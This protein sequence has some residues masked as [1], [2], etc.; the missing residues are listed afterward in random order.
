MLVVSA[1][2]S[3]AIDTTAFRACV[4]DSELPIPTGTAGVASAA[5]PNFSLKIVLRTYLS[6][7]KQILSE[8]NAAFA[9]L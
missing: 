5:A 9:Y 2:P 3:A 6:C 7:Q 1:N 4:A 8:K